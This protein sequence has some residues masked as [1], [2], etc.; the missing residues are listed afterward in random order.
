MCL[1]VVHERLRSKVN[2]IYCLYLSVFGELF[3]KLSVKI[4]W[5][6]FFISRRFP[7]ST[8]K[9]V[10]KYYQQAVAWLGF[11]NG[12][13]QKKNINEYTKF[14]SASVNFLNRILKYTTLFV[15]DKYDNCCKQSDRNGAYLMN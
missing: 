7:A 1:T 15:I 6:L 11:V 14:L 3:S 9:T 13:R 4:N 5:I 2:Y 12:R 8:C 10:I